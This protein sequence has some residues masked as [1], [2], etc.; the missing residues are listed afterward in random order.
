MCAISACPGRS[1]RELRHRLVVLVTLGVFTCFFVLDLAA[2]S[3]F[4]AQQPMTASMAL[5]R[6]GHTATLL[7]DGTVLVVGGYGTLG[8]LNTAERYD[9][10]DVVLD[11]QRYLPWVVRSVPPAAPTV[12]IVPTITPPIFTFPTPTSAI[13][14]IATP[15]PEFYSAEQND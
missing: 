4:L 12:T 13:F 1:T 14:P 3:Q 8:P 15:T 10:R 11:I 7:A 5:A 9:P 2:K 6:S